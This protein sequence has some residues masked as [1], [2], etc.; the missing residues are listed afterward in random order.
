MEATKWLNQ[1]H[2]QFKN[3]CQTTLINKLID[4]PETNC[5][6]N[7]GRSRALS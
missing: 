2:K 6:D 4:D 3:V 5:T 1:H 7:A